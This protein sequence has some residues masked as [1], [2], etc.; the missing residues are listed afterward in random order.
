MAESQSIFA[1]SSTQTHSIT[2]CTSGGGLGKFLIST[3]S[4]FESELSALTAP[5]YA[6]IASSRSARASSAIT[7]TSS[8]VFFTAAS[9]SATCFF[10]SSAV[11]RSLFTC[12]SI[13][14]VSFDLVA[15]SG[16]SLLSSSC[17][18][19]TSALVSVSFFVPTLSRRMPT[20][21]ASRFSS[22][23]ETYS[24]SRSRNDLGVT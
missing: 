24:T 17:M 4:L 16:C 14:S 20:S 5:R 13:C 21:I 1:P 11:A 7:C 12:S 19:C 23:D 9:S 2:F 15:S 10:F 3:M 18:P 22:S 8:A 6:G